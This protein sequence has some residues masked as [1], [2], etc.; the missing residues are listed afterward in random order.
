MENYIPKYF[1]NTTTKQTLLSK[2][3]FMKNSVPV[4]RKRFVAAAI[5]MV[6]INLCAGM[7]FGQTPVPMASQP[8]LT[9][10]ETFN[11]IST[12]SNNF[13]G[14]VTA[15]T[16]WKNI[17]S[18]SGSVPAATAVT[19]TTVFSTG[20]TAGVQKG[21]NNMVFLSTG[22]TSSTTSTAA[23]FFMD[24]TGV[25]AGTLSVDLAEVNNS[26]GDRGASLKIFW[27][28]DGTTWTELT[29]TNL[30]FSAVNNVTSSASITGLALPSAFNNSATARLRFYYYNGPTTGTTGSRPKISID[31][32]VVTAVSSGCSSAPTG[33]SAT[34]SST[35]VCSGATLTLTGAATGATSY[36][37]SGPNSFS[38]TAQVASFSVNTLSAGS[39]TLSATNA[40]GTSTVSS[41]AITINTAPTGVSATPSGT[42]LCSG[43]TLTLTG[44]ATGAIS[45]LWSGPNSYSSTLLNPAGFS[46]GPSSGSYTLAATN[47]CGTTSVTTSAVTIQPA[48]TSVSAT[49][50]ATSLC[51][52]GTLTLTGA[53]TS[54]TSY[55]W[56]GPNAFSS[57]LLSPAAFTVGT[58]SAGSYTL[59]A[60]NSC[61]TT[62]VATTAITINTSPS[63]VSA[64]SSS[65]TLCT[66]ST[67]TLTGAATGATS[68]A[69]SGPN[70]FSST[71][72]NPAS[73]SVSTLSAG[74]YTLSATNSCGSTT[75]TT[76]S[77]TVNGLPSAPSFTGT[78]TIVY[79]NSTTLSFS[80]GANDVVYYWTGA[81]TANTTLSAGGAASFTVAPSSTTTYSVTGVT[82]SAGCSLSSITGVTVTITVT[83]SPADTIPTMDDN[84]AMG[85]PSGA[86]TSTSDVN[87][88][89]MVKP[90]YA[91][92]YN[93]SKGEANWVSW[94]LS[95]AW[96]GS[97]VRCDC[98]YQDSTLP[99]GYY[100]AATGNYTGSGFDRGHM[101]PSDDRDLNDADNMATF[102]MTNIAPQAPNLNQIT[103]ESL[104]SYC[105]ALIYAGN[106]LYVISGGY[107][108]GGTGSA[109]SASTIAS[110]NINV[111]SRYFKV[112]VVLPVGTNDVNRVTTSTRVIAVDMPNTQTVNSQTWGYYRTSVDAIEAATG[113]DF[114][115]NVPTGIQS[116][117]E[118]GVDNGPTNV[119]AWDL[120]GTGG[121]ATFAATSV[122]SNLDASSD[123]NLLTRGSGAAASTGANSFRTTGF[124]NNGIST[125]NTDYFQVKMKPVS[126]KRLSLSTIDATCTGTTS[127]AASPGVTSQFAYSFDGST[128]TLIGSPMVTVGAPVNLT[129]VN[130]S[131]ISALQNISSTSTLYIRYYASGQTTTGGWG[132]YSQYS[133]NYGLSFDGS[134][135]DE[136]CT[137]APTA[138]SAS[139]SSATVCNGGTITLS[140][141]ATSVGAT[142]YSW[143]GPNSYSSTDLSPA[144]FTVGTAAAGVYTLVATNLCGSTTATTAALTVDAGPTSVSATP[145][146][147]NVCSGNTLTLTGTATGATSYS[148]SGPNSY[149]ATDLVPAAFTVGTASAGIYTLTAT[150][151]CGT[152]TATTTSVAVTT[153][154][155]VAAISGSTTV[156]V[157]S[158]ITLT[159]ATAGGTW[160]SGTTSVATITSGG[161][162]AGVSIGSSVISYTVSNLCGSTTVTLSVNVTAAPDV[163]TFSFTAGNATATSSSSAQVPVAGCTAAIGNSFG[164]VS[165]PIVTTSA[166]SSYTGA[167]GTYNIGNAVNVTGNTT[168]N[169]STSPYISF[170][171]TPNAGYAIN[172]TGISFGSRG[173]ATGPGSYTVST[174]VGGFGSAIGSGTLV[175]NSSWASYT[176][177]IA[178]VTGAAGTAITVRI[179]GYGGT[180]SPSSNTI[181]WKLD[182]IKFTYTT[183]ASCSGAPTAVSATPSAT[184]LCSGNTLTL[185]GA[186]TGATSYAWSGPNSF[187]STA[188]SPA[189]FTVNTASAGIY[190]LV[191]SNPCGS[192]TTTTTAITV[193]TTPTS[194]TATPSA[195]TICNGETLTLTGAATDATSYTWSGPASYTATDLNPAAF[196]VGTASAGVYTLTASNSCGNT[197]ATTSAITIGTSPSAV[198]A[199]TTSTVCVGSTITL[200]GTASGATTYSWSGPG[201]YSSTD[202]NPAGF[203]ATTGAAGIYTLTATNSC[204]ST[205][206]TTTSVTVNDV[207]SAVS[208]NASPATLCTGTTL[209]LTGS[210]TGATSY[211]W[212]GPNSFSS[213]DLNP[214]SFTVNTASAGVYTLTATNTCGN[215]T[216]TTTAVTVNGLPAPTLTGATTIAFGT[217]TT[218]TFTGT[219]GDIINYSW[220]GGGSSSTTIGVSGTSVV[221]VSP[222]STTTYSIDN[223]T[224]AVGCF[225]GITGQSAT[226]TVDMGCT[227]AP[228]SVTAALSS[229]A[230]CN[231]GTLTLTGTATNASSYSWSGPDGFTSTDLNPAAFTTG[232]AA[233]GVYTLTATNLCGS[234]TATTAALTILSVPASV[235]ATPSAT[236]LCPGNTLTLTGSATGATTY[237]WSGPDSYSA[238]DLNPAAFTAGTAAA[239]IYTLSATNSCG[240][241]TATTAGI[242]ILSIPASV[243]ATPSATSVCAGNTLTLT[244]T[245]TG[246]TA[247]SWSGPNSYSS[248]DLNPAAFT[249]GTAAAGVYTLS[250]TNSC[251]TTTATT[252]AIT[253]LS[254]PSAVSAT[255][256]ATSLCSGNTLTLTGAATDATSYSWSG[257]NSFSSTSLNPAAFTVGTASA[258]VYTLSATNSC[259][260]TTATTTSVAVIAIPTVAAISGS[261][262]VN[263]GSNITLTNA[264][265]GGTWTSG[266]TSVAT[267]T[268][269]GVVAGVST[270]SSIISYTVSN[271]CGSATATLSV[272]VTTAADN[273]T[274]SFT[275]GNATATSSSS[276]QVPVAGCTAAIGNSFGTVATPIATTSG[277][278]GYTGAT[279]TYN[280]G[281]AVNVTGNTTF[282]SSSSPYMSFTLTPNAGYAINLTGISFGSRATGSGPAA[283]TISTSVGGFG[284]AI[285]TGTLSTAGSWSLVS[286]TITSVTGATGTAITVRIYG[287]G[288]TGSPSSGTIN[289]RLDD[290]KFTYTATAGCSGAPTAVSATASAT[291]LCSGNTLTLTGAA[292]GA[293][294]YAWSGPN[295]FS[296]TA[297]S[298]ASFTVNTASAG[299]YTLVATNSCGSTTATTTAVTVNPLPAPGISGTTTIAAG[300]TATLT[301]AGVNGDV[302]NYSW[303]GGGSSST[304]IDV[305]GTSVVTVSPSSTTTYSISSATSAAGCAATITG[306]TATVTV[307]LGCTVAP[308]A[309]SATLSSATLCV[310]NTL[311]L[312]GSAT[313]GL[314]YS[315]SG[316]NGYSSTDLNPASVTVG[317]ASAGVY[318]L[319]ATNACGSTTATTG[320]LTINVLPSSVSAT[321][322]ATSLC[323]GNTLTLTGAA[324]DATSYS[325]SGPNS[326]SSTSLNPAAF[327]VGTA[328]A[329]VYT[330][331]ATN[332]CGTTTATTTSVAVI[333]I[334]TVAAISGS[335]SVNVGSNITLTNATAGGTWTSGTTSVATIT[336]GG[337]VTGVSTG[338][339]IIS[340]TVSNVCGSATATLS[341]AVTTAA[342]NTTFSFTAGNATATSSSSAQV[343]VAGCTAAIGNS[344][345]TVATPIATTSGSSGYTGA[346]G[347]YNI[348]NAV[349]VT[350]N[351]TFNSSSSPYM[352]FTL[353][354]NTGYAIN[355]TGIS[356]GSRATGSGPAA[357]TISTSVGGFGSAISTGTLST[358]GSWSLV[359]P[360]ITSVTGATGT[361]I[362]IRIYGYGGTGSPSSGTINWRLDD[363][364]FTYTAAPTC[365]GAPTAV[366]AT[367]SAATLC[368]GSAL[369][370]T[371]AATGAISYS[372]TGPNSFSSTTLSPASFTVN[373]ASAGVY[374]LVATNPCGST[375]ATTTIAV[376]TTP[377][378]VSA[379]PSA[380]TLC[381]GTTLTL[382]G[383][384]TDATSYSWSGPGSYSATDLN[385]VAFTVNTAS[386]GIYTLTATNSCGNTIATTSAITIGTAPSAV[387]ATA[388]AATV[389]LGSTL[390]L[391]GAAT[392]AD[393]YSWSG[394]AG[395]SST[396]LNPA[397]IT[398]DA[399]VAGIYTLTTTN[400]C[401]STTATTTSVSVSD[402]P[403]VVSAN[404]SATTICG[405]ST[406]TLTGT[407]T[408][409]TSYSWSGPGGYSST[410]LNPAG[411]TAT[412]SSAGIYTLT[413]INSCGS[414]TASTASV[415]VNN[416][417]ISV[418][419]NASATTLCSGDVLTLTGSATD[420]TDYSWSGPGGYTSTDLNPAAFTVGTVAA[421]I[422]TLTATNGCGIATATTTAI[423]V[424]TSPASVS[425]TPSAT[426]MCIGS[427]LTLTG[428]ATGADTYSWSGPAG[429]SSTDLNPAAFTVGTLN[430]GIYS[431]TATNTCGSTIATTA[432]IAVLTTPTVAAI[433][434][435]SSVNV[436]STIALTNATA[437]GTWTSTTTY[438]A[439]VSASGTV[440]GVANGASIISYTI[441]N[442][443]GSATSTLSVSVV[444]TVSEIIGWNTSPNSATYGP[445]P[446]APTTLNS[447]LT[448]VSGLNRGAGVA[449]TGTAANRAWGGTDWQNSTAANA[450][451]NGDTINYI[452]KPKP[453]Y[454]L[455]FSTFVLN[456]RRPTSG[457]TAGELQYS[458]N[459]S[460]YTTAA[461]LSYSSTSSSGA[462]VPTVTLSGITALQNIPST[463]SVTFRI[464]NYG[465]TGS[466]GTWYIFDVASSTASDMYF[467]GTVSV[468]CSIAPS[469]VTATPSATTV[470]NGNTLSLTGAAT[471][472]VS[473]SWTGPNG[474]SSTAQSPAAFTVG[475]A[476]AG[477][478][479][480]VASN[481]C[482]TVT[483]VTTPSISVNTVPGTASAVLSATTLCSGSTLSLTGSATDASSYSWSGPGGFTATGATPAAFT[484]NTASAG[485]YTLTATNSCGTSSVVSTALTVNALPAPAIAGTTTVII[486]SGTTL[487][488][489]GTAGDVINYSWTGGGSASTTIDVSGS[490]IVSV[491]PTSTTTYSITSATSALGCAA[492]VTGQQATVTVDLGCTGAPTG[493]T[494]SLSAGSVCSGNTL[495][496]TGT[497]TDALTYSWSGPGGYTSS[498]LNPAGITVTGASAGIYTLSAT[499]SCGTTTVTTA[500]LVIST[501]PAAVSATTSASSLC[502]GATLSLTGA[503]T[504]A[505]S[506]SW[507]GPAGYTSTDANPAPFAVNTAS[508]GTYTLTAINNC[509]STTATAS[510]AVITAPT[511]AAV[512]PSSGSIVAGNQLTLTN[513]T[514]GG[515]W[516][517]SDLAVAG[518]SGTGVVT[519]F[520][521]GSATATYTVIN[522]CGTAYATSTI[523]VTAPADGTIYLNNFGATTATASDAPA[524]LDAH[525]TTPT[526][527]WTSTT[528]LTSFG[529][530]S[531]QA[532][533]MSN[534]SGTPSYTLTLNVASGYT[535]SVSA[536]NFWRNHSSTGASHW[537]LSINGTNVGSGDLVGTTGAYV[538]LTNVSTPITNLTG[539][540]TVK[541]QL[542]GA[543]GTGTFRLDDFQLNG[544]VAG[545]PLPVIASGPVNDTIVSGDNSSFTVTASGATSYQW[546]RNTS[547]L[548]GG[549]WTNITSA[550]LDPA[551][552]TYSS[553]STTTTATSNTL[554]LSSVPV[555]WNGYA[556]RCVVTNS[557]GS[558]TSSAAQLTVVTPPACSGTPVA[559]SAAAT[560]TAFCGSGSSAINTTG[561]TLATGLAYQW[562]SSS[563]SSAWSDITGATST[564]YTTPVITG[565]TYYR[566]AVTCSATSLTGYTNGAR[567]TINPLPVISIP[568]TVAICSGTSGTLVTASGASSYTWTPATGLSAT[569]GASVLV[570][571][572]TNRTYTITG[573]SA[574]GCVSTNTMSA[575]YNITPAA[576]AIT[577]SYLNMCPSSAPQMLTIPGG[578]LSASAVYS[579]SSITI[580]GG[581]TAYSTSTLTASAVPAGAYITGVSVNFTASMPWQAD[582][583]I[584]LVSPDG[585]VLNL[586]NLKGIAAATT[587]NFS[588]TTV[589][590]AGGA[591]FPTGSTVPSSTTFSADA[592]AGV[593]GSTYPSNASNFNELLGTVNG[594]W[595]LVFYQATSFT[596]ANGTL[597]NWSL[598]FNYSRSVTWSPATNL[599]TDAAGTVAYTGAATDTVYAAAPATTGVVN[600]IATSSNN[601]CTSAATDTINVQN[602]PAMTLGSIPTVCNTLSSISVPYS[603]SSGTTTYSL[604]WNSA[605]LAAGF[606]NVTSAPLPASYLSIATPGSTASY[607]DFSGVITVTDAI[608]T[609]PATSLTVTLLH[610][611]SAS[612]TAYDA[613]C[614][615][616]PAGIVITGTPSSTIHYMVDSGSTVTADI[617]GTGSLNL[618]T[619]IITAPHNY[620]ISYVT[621]SICYSA[622]DT[623][624]NVTPIPMQWLGGT[625]G[626]E[627]DWNT[628]TNWACGFVPTSAD[629]VI[630]NTTTYM[631]VLPTT[632]SATVNDL[633][634]ASGSTI[635]L[636]GSSVINVK[637][638]IYNSGAVNGTG[639]VVMNGTSAQKLYGIGTISNLE[640]DNANGATIQPGART[641]ISSTLYL[642]AGTLTTNDSLE[643]LSTD[644]F[645]TARIAEIPPTGA[646]VSGRVKTDQYVQGGYRRWRFWGHCFSDTISLSQLQP[647][648]DI[649][650]A[651]GSSRGFTTTT[652]NAPSAYWHNTYGSADDSTGYDPGWRAF[653]DIR[654][655]AAD[656]NRLHPGQGIR[657]FFRGSK[658]EGLGYLGYYG[659]YTPSASISKMIGHVNQGA[660]SVNLKRGTASQTLNQLSNPYPSPVDLGTA[661]Y[662]ARQS[663]QITG[664]AFYVWNPTLGAGGQYM[665][666]P[667][668]TSAPEPFYL[669][670]NTSYQVRAAYDGAHLDFQESYKSAATTVNLFRAPANAVRFNIYDSNY[671]LWDVLSMQF[672]DKASDAEDKLLDAIKPAGLDFNFYSIAADG[673]RLAVDARPYE[674]DKVIPLGLNSAYQQDYVIRAESIS[675]PAGGAI[676]LHDKL[677]NKYVEMK[678]GTEYRF[679]IGKD[680]ATQ[681]NE[682]FELSLKPTTAAVV[683]A[684][685]VS[686]APNPAS[687]D[688]QITFTS[689]SKDHVSVRIMDVSGVSIYNQD[690]G[691]KQNG[692]ITVPMSNFAA[693]VYM[694]EITQGDQKITKRLVKE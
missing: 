349:N 500:S 520:S 640:L 175:A 267:I 385:P 34:P 221:T 450:V 168:F 252:T 30:P 374:T 493:V 114:L 88:Y 442:I 690:L 289:W 153:I 422:Y 398:A 589:S 379:T 458:V 682:R 233:A 149:S 443:C 489:S 295:S 281:N 569:T 390:T 561:T 111:P 338:S 638:D 93:N 680:R 456:Y 596:N 508:A 292:T 308:T 662:Y 53:A 535:L 646:S 548:S 607:G 244:G 150:N 119:L 325:W 625:T 134:F 275:A 482:G 72:L 1:I 226:I 693:G 12:W 660:V 54:A 414:T 565:T 479:T 689:G 647:Y 656:S 457:P 293:T 462:T 427:A 597:S 375:T 354:P 337:V 177:S 676:T 428:A 466:S 588:N 126:G 657:L 125:A 509:G 685:E 633:D 36:S 585:H 400:S 388:S 477:V 629:S 471:N 542:S 240:T 366:S 357:Y 347:T 580:N 369:T 213:T 133:G 182:D 623:V 543:S 604:T 651:G 340:Y 537:V 4:R 46:A 29:T 468:D 522:T 595:R 103:W 151:S 600:Y 222:T 653:N 61:G 276:A 541:L 195:T 186:A 351:T 667:I 371:G 446:F 503:A 326:F 291:T 518:I 243:S 117:I 439:T 31:N 8:S 50:S 624:L 194:V 35:I 417:P 322:S 129:T 670:A 574:A 190:T 16:R 14:S 271:V 105:R 256:S 645:A 410:D 562:Q 255:P 490:T 265:A 223:A 636:D 60:T 621:E 163:T 90:Q 599:F 594:N 355:L 220:T 609:G 320:T 87:N 568:A 288:G 553:Y 558:V 350:G 404:V 109:G 513:A 191:A 97:A 258:G 246:A 614:M 227:A 361:A 290:I 618:T 430:A 376:N 688:V 312:T 99:S 298:P 67:L 321:P 188:L 605:A 58:A 19:A 107:G 491:T 187:S 566:M 631:P 389:C 100:R 494:A 66:G 521:A 550:G 82:S 96:K 299:V 348:G 463:S 143:T 251:G 559:G 435:S 627:T 608:C 112:I 286:P 373:T 346:T 617:D 229:A 141:S 481:A 136:P 358:A 45:Y 421:G 420:A 203:S 551:P 101:C 473:Y 152:T 407:A 563:D 677:L 83:G 306:Q 345:G 127:F 666:I 353:T 303:T 232:T 142:T 403:S 649:T 228:T 593:G 336:S 138:V 661:A 160:T 210:A 55:A 424:N 540:V 121:D 79:G 333:A 269:G 328:S 185:T 199:T 217:S 516:T 297:L 678:E 573:T 673:R 278:S 145:S 324:T 395:Y 485:A 238:T 582:Y 616:H 65:T 455:S 57:T 21:T 69:W 546:Q 560:T 341:V 438:A 331:S 409:A 451:A 2:N 570:N 32:L 641:M 59:A 318:T 343:P 441:T 130:V 147:A 626:H 675:V 156:T 364:K 444:P 260:T 169:S 64:T 619:G 106:E 120:T 162:V 423:A 449:V 6:V 218:L 193:N 601:G 486:G 314:S 648:I 587:G 612:V 237:S 536:F 37:W 236:S 539:T 499:N 425:A 181:N 174:S 502:S 137:T 637:G 360:T 488:F 310:G 305:S 368:S 510:V 144:S 613:P 38:S 159:N 339:S 323:S 180:G 598:T 49:P 118:S 480:L 436:G 56:S 76:A 335:S 484:V 655:T 78:A 102:K 474:F 301:F 504:G 412:T 380:T 642:T 94:H 359:S 686:M 681:G 683:K 528:A 527:A 131:S 529:G 43:A 483:T 620:T 652:T 330:L 386:A 26:S 122:S 464:A 329:G 643:L 367:A 304:T 352:S 622:I 209:T 575:T 13:G 344:F 316:P 230:I 95:T 342:H 372:W 74:I 578:P 694:V 664:Y 17:S 332:S 253:I 154:P 453:G 415:T 263:V 555:S 171:L 282:N 554:N 294:S 492:T 505:T 448:T 224:S 692:V 370:L 382:T 511:V 200:N 283:Y 402:I 132:F 202:L 262:S 501:V 231:G 684:L 383:A 178:S 205:T 432:S 204:G 73:F 285:S 234:T 164:T 603:V 495:T 606:A 611:P 334:P 183:T 549:T 674:G 669:P 584:N 68:F 579:G 460:A 671:H 533:S 475:T 532:L 362:T 454:K 261:S 635:Q 650:G 104:E 248:T 214:A 572:T 602:G 9:Y 279:G 51:A 628:A 514:A 401:G 42:S 161:V 11:A 478:Y 33:V 212:S 634:I 77:V 547:G 327:T 148:W 235:S 557:G 519:G 583:V 85:N 639:R 586:T 192:T 538:G 365:S 581:A 567:I 307:D 571:T 506:Y 525:L 576:M 531:G 659:M 431:L 71:S 672:N 155:T 108:S 92:S 215:T 23:D 564:S 391:T 242:T 668:G 384:A 22:T 25:N 418:I 80:G 497:A 405:G 302:I 270:G 216:A 39:Y 658:G 257:P 62:T 399:S 241:T 691:A 239:G 128:F 476:S 392:G 277:S 433:S 507:S 5:L 273:T 309:V 44:A 135:S 47:S 89:L 300:G 266:T 110:G 274:F 445:S 24:F 272:A 459:G 552:G 591:T 167:T 225:A 296:S 124:Q 397:G 381:E 250:A 498:D 496:L 530:A 394:P 15:E 158:N 165:T 363:I 452:V 447:N 86:T 406:L 426:S 408:D 116:V 434:G 206:A 534:S 166:S 284:S 27:S 469:S 577:P 311:T 28:T 287:Y 63:G 70:S 615:G 590:S 416:S 644:T 268:S 81:G 176:T 98:F 18:S 317:T 523:S 172:L 467:T 198:T 465:G 140:G 472:A 411:F 75:A 91:L 393:A 40:C 517:I 440:Y 247:Y 665:A 512:S 7:A 170:T 378:A 84:M 173:T 48:P 196:T 396:D 146:A 249:V 10:T 610:T 654:L 157:G 123:L 20:S 437:G 356:F 663:G 115:S 179:Y 679:T 487:T 189:S 245:A 219:T 264:T 280:I 419:A 515:T 254:A 545:H 377:T 208:A 413:A 461:T 52:G 470:C 387:T 139:L 211:S 592:V 3:A 259:G 41:V 632:V 197:I 184:T 429:F 201:V 526:P 319:T 544:I 313:N 687:D 315:W 207:P 630:I 524:I 556:Y 113:Y